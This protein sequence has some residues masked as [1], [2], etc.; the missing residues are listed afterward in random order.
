MKTRICLCL[1]TLLL[2]CGGVMA[3][4]IF[5]P[6]YSFE[7]QS[8]N[9]GAW[10][11][12]NITGWVRTR[13][14]TAGVFNPQDENYPGSAGA[15]GELPGTAHG[16]Q[17]AY[18]NNDSTIESASSLGAVQNNTMYVLTVAV[19][20]RYDYPPNG[21]SYTIAILVDGIVEAS[22]T[23]YITEDVIPLGT[24][25]DMSTSFTT[26]ENDY[27]AGGEIKISLTH[28]EDSTLYGQGSFDNVRLSAVEPTSVS[29]IL[30][31]AVTAEPLEG[32]EVTY[33]S[34]R[35]EFWQN[36]FTDADGAFT[37]A[38]LKSG[39]AEIKARPDV[40]SGYA[41]NL[42]WLINTV[43]LEEGE[44]RSGQIIALREGALVSGYVKDSAGQPIA[45]IEVEWV[46]RMCDGWLDTDANGYYEMRLPVGEYKITVY[47]EDE[48]IGSIG[49]NV[50]IADVSQS[51]VV[52]DIV[53]YTEQTGSAISGSVVNSGAYSKDGFFGIAAFEAGTII[54]P[55][56]LYSIMP[57]SEAGLMEAGSYAIAALPSDRIYD[58]YLL[59]FNESADGIESY[60][61]RD[62][63]FN[64]SPGATA[65]DLYYTSEGGTV[66]GSVENVD[67]KA[68]VGAYVAVMDISGHGE[69]AGFT[70]TDENGE[71][72][73]HNVGAGQY[74]AAALH[75]MYG[76]AS[77]GS[78]VEV[79]DGGTV[80]VGTISMAFAGDKE[81]GNLNGD[82]V[83]DMQDF[84]ELADGWMQSGSFEA[85]LDQD[86]TVGIED[87]LRIS[88]T[89]LYRPIW[90]NQ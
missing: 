8:L 87:L 39:P 78:V 10:L 59:V 53:V 84:A 70:N 19:G 47:S 62:G 60:S 5:V 55:N 28:D 3:D 88:E 6:N 66:A 46:G 40:G 2:V 27:R 31:D 49:A 54:D 16:S 45:D 44:E 63:Q 65:V 61:V 74:V 77:A 25:V 37:L 64:V 75:S 89:W 14:G 34:D 32:V 38:G 4:A 23:L 76:H 43:V 36:D 17:L 26:S 30:V 85:D 13:S 69:V 71:Y 21:S 51:V 81:A 72:V 68:V 7:E 41:W 79:T 11:D 29:G 24:F 57:V 86:G 1:S 12:N 80:N 50:T 83:V 15:D 67:G 82:G 58:F 52:N 20:S 90:Y 18:I 42:P 33:W 22:E 48:T 35:H 73:I 9:D 56:S